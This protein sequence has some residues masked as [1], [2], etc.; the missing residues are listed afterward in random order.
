[1]PRMRMV[2]PEFWTDSKVVRVSRDARLLFIGLWNFADCDAGHVEADPFGLK[3]K[4]FPAD[5][6][7]VDALLA[8]LA[9]IGLIDRRKSNVG[10]FILVPGLRSHQKTDARWTPRCRV[11]QAEKEGSLKL[12]ETHVSLDE[13]A[14]TH[15]NSTN[16]APVREG[17]GEVGEGEVG[18]GEVYIC[19][20]SEPEFAPERHARK[21]AQYPDAFEQF[22]EHYPLKRD[23][24]K[25]LKAWK[26]AIKRTDNDTL[27]A[28]A[29]RYRDDPNRSDQYTK[30]AEGWLNGDGW[31]DDPLPE[32]STGSPVSF[33]ERRQ[34]KANQ[35]LS[36]SRG[37][38]PWSNDSVKWQ[39]GQ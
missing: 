38:D 9:Q 21:R 11:C 7:N 31:E 18:K 12:T 25:A 39:L 5:D 37:G 3:M 36:S 20:N 4:I 29:V 10:D 32:R 27:I 33:D 14:E 28:G 24:R 15:Q 6:V 8:E 2:K 17:R 23:K 26:S 13:F 30:Y 34:Q 16:L 35:L 19:A 22:W 1:M